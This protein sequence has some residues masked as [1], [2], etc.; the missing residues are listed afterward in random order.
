MVAYRTW[1]ISTRWPHRPPQ[2]PLQNQLKAENQY[3]D[4]G[5]ILHGEMQSSDCTMPPLKKSDLG[6][7]VRGRV[8]VP[9][10]YSSF[11]QETTNSKYTSLAS[12]T[13]SDARKIIWA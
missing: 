12:Q 11:L 7:V 2:I 8:Y 3:L 5:R 13:A 4:E 9:P 1:G 6:R 10:I